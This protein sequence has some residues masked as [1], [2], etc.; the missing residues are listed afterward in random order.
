MNNYEWM[1][2]KRT[3]A[4]RLALEALALPE[5]ENTNRLQYKIALCTEAS[6]DMKHRVYVG[7]TSG[8]EAIDR[9]PV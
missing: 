9:S 2:T 6:D 7:F 4:T 8:F 5:R 3:S 1:K